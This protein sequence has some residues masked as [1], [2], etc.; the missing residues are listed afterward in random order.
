MSEQQ[1]ERKIQVGGDTAA[2]PVDGYEP[3]PIWLFAIFGALL[4]WGGWYLG[5][6]NAGWDPYQLDENWAGRPGTAASQPVEDPIALGKR[7]Y[8]GNCVSCHQGDGNGLPGQ[9][10][11]LHA[12]EWVLGNPAWMK[13][14][15]LNGLE[16]PITVNGQNYNNAMPALGTKLTDK[17]IAAV[18]TYVR[19][20]ADWKN[21]ASQ[22]TADAVAATRAA[23]KGRSTPWTA[24]ELRAI[25]ADE[26]PT[27]APAQAGGQPSG[28]ASNPAPPPQ[29]PQAPAS[30][31]ASPGV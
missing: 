14:I 11:T 3:I 12:S 18:I 27:P 13:R 23:V 26:Q 9:Y 20:N 5:V 21:N 22:V 17:Q 8:A 24:E 29:N 4:L 19:T 15:I 10:P 1:D 16:G 28:P 25:T 6:H 30:A 2:D 7:I 31:P